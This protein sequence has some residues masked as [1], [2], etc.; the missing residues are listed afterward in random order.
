VCR[1]RRLASIREGQGEARACSLALPVEAN[2]ARGWTGRL[3]ARRFGRKAVEGGRDHAHNAWVLL[4]GICCRRFLGR[5]RNRKTRVP[6]REQESQE[7]QYEA[8]R[9]DG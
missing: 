6:R 5:R 1:A 8:R 2:D 7:G 9:S 4:K 3:T